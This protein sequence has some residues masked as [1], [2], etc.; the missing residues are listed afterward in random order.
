MVS[1]VGMTADLR[2]KR[3][4]DAKVIGT[5]PA[6]SAALY[7]LQD[8]N[9][10][11]W[12]SMYQPKNGAR[13]ACIEIP[14]GQGVCASTRC[15]TT[16][17]KSSLAVS[18]LAPNGPSAAPR[19]IRAPR[20]FLGTRSGPD[21]SS[22]IKIIPSPAISLYVGLPVLVV[23]GELLSSVLVSCNTYST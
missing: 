8:A 21:S 5:K 16:L 2:L 7:S 18:R 14:P 12:I 4:N 1:E 17:G 15:S 19:K 22:S 6:A 11:C 13:R 9:P 10:T 23:V 3:S 20:L